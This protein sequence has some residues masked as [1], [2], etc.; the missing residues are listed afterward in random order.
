MKKNLLKF[1]APLLLLA[2]YF[3][4]VGYQSETVNDDNQQERAV[5]AEMNRCRTNP[6]NYAETTLRKHLE[7]FVDEDTYQKSDGSLIMTNEGRARVLEAID[8]LKKMQPVGTLTYNEELTKA[9]RFHC[10]DTGP[11]GLTG[12][13]SSDGTRMGIRVRRYMKEKVALA[14]NISY[15][16]SKAEDIVLQLVIDDGVPSR[17]HL[18]NIMNSSYHRAGVAIGLH[19]QYGYMCTI[20]FSE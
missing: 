15:G 13:N 1:T 20:D 18:K 7:R 4:F 14:E 9:A 12:H 3:A 2:V 17:G 5:I 8:E 6:S 11:T 19:K 16:S 10:E